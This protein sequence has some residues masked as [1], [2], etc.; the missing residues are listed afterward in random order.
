MERSRH[1]N[2]APSGIGSRRGGSTNCPSASLTLLTP[3]VCSRRLGSE[4]VDARA[5]DGLAIV[6]VGDRPAPARARSGTL[7]ARSRE[8]AGARLGARRR[9]ARRGDAGRFEGAQTHVADRREQHEPG[10]ARGL[11][12]GGGREYQRRA[13]PRLATRDRPSGSATSAAWA[14]ASRG[15]AQLGGAVQRAGWSPPIVRRRSPRPSRSSVAPAGLDAPT[16]TAA[17]PPA[18]CSTTRP[19]SRTRS[20]AQRDGFRLRRRALGRSLESSHETRGP[21]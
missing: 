19:S 21:G 14:E 1:C 13:G 12:R 3:S 18:R 15:R 17:R 11:T 2:R 6:R 16:P 7:L 9:C 20:G 10:P 4:R 8:I 5:R